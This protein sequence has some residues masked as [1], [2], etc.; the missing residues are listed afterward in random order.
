MAYPMIRKNESYAIITI[1]PC[2]IVKH[3]PN[4]KSYEKPNYRECSN[5]TENDGKSSRV[6][7]LVDERGCIISKKDLHEPISSSSWLSGMHD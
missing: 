3:S 5:K 1:P 7:S 2:S 4:T 6:L